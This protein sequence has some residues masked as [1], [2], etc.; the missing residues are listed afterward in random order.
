M[1]LEIPILGIVTW[2]F[3]NLRVTIDEEFSIS[4]YCYPKINIG[5]TFVK[6]SAKSQ[7]YVKTYWGFKGTVT[8]KLSHMLL[9]IVGK[10][11]LKGLSSD[12]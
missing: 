3:R 5:T 12:H 6:S 4:G 11:S 8:Q 2:N 9:Y 10:L 1:Y 7:P